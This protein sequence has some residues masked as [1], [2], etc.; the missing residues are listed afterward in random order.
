ML[1]HLHQ[2]QSRSNRQLHLIITTHH[3][4]SFNYPVI[5]SFIHHSYRK[6]SAKRTY[7]RF[8]VH[9]H[10]LPSLIVPRERYYLFVIAGLS[11][12]LLH[13]ITE[14]GE[15][16]PGQLF[17]H[18]AKFRHSQGSLSFM[19]EGSPPT[20]WQLLASSGYHTTSSPSG[21]HR[22]V[23]RACTP[24]IDSYQ[25]VKERIRCGMGRN[26]TSHNQQ[27][28]RIKSLS[29]PPIG[30]HP[31]WRSFPPVIL[32]LVR[33]KLSVVCSWVF[34]HRQ[35]ST[36]RSCGLLLSQRGL[37]LSG[38]SE[39]EF[40]STCYDRLLY[41]LGGVFQSP[42]PFCFFVTLAVCALFSLEQPLTAVLIFPFTQNIFGLLHHLN[43][44]GRVLVFR[45]DKLLSPLAKLRYRF[46]QFIENFHHTHLLYNVFNTRMQC[47]IF[48]LLCSSLQQSRMASSCLICSF[49]CVLISFR[50]KRGGFPP[51]IPYFN[52]VT[53][54]ILFNTSQLPVLMC[55]SKYS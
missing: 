12:T 35:P 48:F 11:V 54:S 20:V 31:V 42:A 8:C 40:N 41:R 52:T 45:L 4:H 55:S 7:H 23:A 14:R 29:S 27:I 15:Y 39:R 47:S 36:Q 10:A 49:V 21:G 30:G 19:P 5:Q 51:P 18:S 25:Y 33:A 24:V 3:H 2:P 1:A 34:P 22:S 46:L 53:K 26:R 32:R 16:R 6:G 38:F 13:R 9:L 44:F 17:R 37:S 43:Q 50:F 28:E